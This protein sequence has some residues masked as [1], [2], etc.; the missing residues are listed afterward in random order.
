MKFPTGCGPLGKRA[1]E[2]MRLR[3]LLPRTQEAVRTQQR[4]DLDKGGG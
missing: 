1:R 4:A 3:H 2:A